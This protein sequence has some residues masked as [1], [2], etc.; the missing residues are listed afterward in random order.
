MASKHTLQYFNNLNT[1]IYSLRLA[2]CILR[3]L[4]VL[5]FSVFLKD[6]DIFLINCFFILKCPSFLLIFFVLM[7]TLKLIKTD[8]F[9]MLTVSIVYLFPSSHFPGYPCL[10]IYDVCSVDKVSFVLDF[11]SGFK[12]SAF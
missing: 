8:H 7:S 12:I 3:F 6:G 5:D 4:F 10:Y 11:I 2:L 9:I 1:E